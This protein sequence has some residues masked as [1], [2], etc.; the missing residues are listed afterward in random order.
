MKTAVA[1]AVVVL[2]LGF[3]VAAR[4]DVKSRTISQ[5]GL[6]DGVMTMTGGSRSVTITSP[7]RTESL[8]YEITPEGEVPKSRTV[9]V[10]EQQD[11]ATVTTTTSERFVE[12]DFVLVGRTTSISSYGTTETVIETMVDGRLLPTRRAVRTASNSPGIVDT[13]TVTQ[14]RKDG[15]FVATSEVRV[16]RIDFKALVSNQLPGGPGLEHVPMAGHGVQTITIIK[17]P[18]DGSLKVVSVRS[19]LDQ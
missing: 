2:V 5:Y 4:A 7:G 15:T 11:R 17:T 9:T 18:V 14:Q 10:R 1:L 13:T 3:G 6:R 16:L 12:K 19:Q 8:S